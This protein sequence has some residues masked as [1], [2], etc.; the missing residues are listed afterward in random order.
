MIQFVICPCSEFDK[1]HLQIM[2]AHRNVLTRYLLTLATEILKIDV[3]L[4]QK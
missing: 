3:I 2:T 1:K 4:Y